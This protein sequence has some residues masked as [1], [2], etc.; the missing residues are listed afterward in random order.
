LKCL[1]GEFVELQVG[2]VLG[3]YDVVFEII[4]IQI[5]DLDLPATLKQNQDRGVRFELPSGPDEVMIRP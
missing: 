3:R 1:V 4:E 5:A 2:E